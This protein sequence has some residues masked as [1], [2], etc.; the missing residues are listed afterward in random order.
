MNLIVGAPLWLV[1]LLAATLIA[2]AVE[3]AV[4]LRISNITCALVFILAVVAMALH[5]FPVDLWQNLVVFLIILTAGTLGFSARLLGGGDV[6]LFA[7]VALWT[8]F[9][10]AVWLTAAVFLS[11]GALAVLFILI[12]PWRRGSTAP[13]GRHGSY[14]IPYGLA[15]VAGAFMIF[16][17]QLNAFGTRA[18]RPN[19]LEL[20]PLG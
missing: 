3:D 19:P 17:L 12:R 15:I 20:P 16:G 13:R 5:G 6:K 9:S 18:E 14:G 2:A 10:A 4:Q 1:G 7:A 11:G 8:S